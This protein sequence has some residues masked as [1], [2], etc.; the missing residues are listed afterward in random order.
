MH[1][2][3]CKKIPPPE[4]FICN[5]LAAFISFFY[6]GKLCCMFHPRCLCILIDYGCITSIP[7]ISAAA[8]T[9]ST[10]LWIP[11]ALICPFCLQKYNIQRLTVYPQSQPALLFMLEEGPQSQ[12]Q[13]QSGFFQAF[14][15]PL[16]YMHRLVAITGYLHT[17]LLIL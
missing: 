9:T 4:G 2:C 11:T 7:C 8:S 15:A 1:S 14:S 3:R 6:R 12:H 13:F 10:L 17:F 5:S 16:Q